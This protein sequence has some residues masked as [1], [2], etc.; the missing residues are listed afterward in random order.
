MPRTAA[1]AGESP[2]HSPGRNPATLAHRK[3]S[4]RQTR[5]SEAWGNLPLATRWAYLAIL[6]GEDRIK[7]A[8]FSV[9]SVFAPL[10]LI[11]EWIFEGSVTL[12]AVC[13][14]VH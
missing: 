10:A 3:S 13:L 4:P 6:P 12:Q 1:G 9:V 8:G 7:T 11:A 2:P 14:P 5:R